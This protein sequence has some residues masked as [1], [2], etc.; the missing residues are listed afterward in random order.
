MLELLFSYL[1]LTAMA[2]V[3]NIDNIVFITILSNRLPEHQQKLG[4]RLGIGLAVG[5]RLVLLFFISWL[6]GLTDPLFSIIS[7]VWHLTGS[8]DLTMAM[9]Q[10]PWILQIDDVSARDLVLMGGGLFL[11]WKASTEIYHQFEDMT[12]ETEKPPAKSSLTSILIQI[13]VL[14]IIFSFDNVITAIGMADSLIIMILAILTAAGIM[15]WF[16]ERIAKFIT[17][18]P[19]LKILALSFLI[20]IGTVLVADGIGAPIAKGY[21]YFA[22]AFSLIVVSLNIK[23]HKLKNND[24]KTN[25]TF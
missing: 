7:L 16:A 24:K 9:T 21:I 11:I 20:L 22:M 15:V 25:F 8:I 14:D 1:A 4:R 12:K 17:E 5:M 23:I 6:I 3:L 13:S 18:H 2:L 19:T 10:I